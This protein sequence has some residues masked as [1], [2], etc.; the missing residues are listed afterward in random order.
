MTTNPEQEARERVRWHLRRE[1]NEL[2][3]EE[4]AALD[5]G[6]TTLH[7]VKVRH[8]QESYA[9][10]DRLCT[11]RYLAGKVAQHRSECLYCASDIYCHIVSTLEAEYAACVAEIQ[12]EGK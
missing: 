8:R 7:Q 5:A 9:A 10:L 2:S 3:A 12:E 11:E 6:E 1:V 4:A